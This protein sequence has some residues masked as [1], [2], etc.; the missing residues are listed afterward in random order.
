MWQGLAPFV[1]LIPAVAAGDEESEGEPLVA[2]GWRGHLKE[3]ERPPP[4]AT[5]GDGESKGGPN[6]LSP[7]PL[8][9]MARGPWRR[10]RY[11]GALVAAHNT[12]EAGVR[13]LNHLSK[14]PW[15]KRGPTSNKE[16]KGALQEAART[17]RETPAFDESLADCVKKNMQQGVL[18]GFA[19]P[20]LMYKPC[21]M[22]GDRVQVD[23]VRQ[24]CACIVCGGHQGA[25]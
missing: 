21:M 1:R 9:L 19:G 24:R 2:A 22:S 15:G 10:A 20:Q 7:T 25:H 11:G 8:R 23:T 12:R 17:V 4:I 5:T 6:T 18:E 13:K 16:K 14:L 3:S